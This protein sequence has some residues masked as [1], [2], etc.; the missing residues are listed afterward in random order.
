LGL[1]DS[2]SKAAYLAII[3]DLAAKGAEAVILG[4]TEI[5]KLVNQAD[6]HVPLLD[7]TRVHAEAA[8]NIATN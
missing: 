1:I 5:G 6:T 8:V 3:E 2:A 4:C 7:T